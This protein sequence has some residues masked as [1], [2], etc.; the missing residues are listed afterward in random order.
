MPAACALTC[1]DTLF[2]TGQTIPEREGRGDFGVPAPFLMRVV[3]TFSASDGKNRLVLLSK[4]YHKNCRGSESGWEAP[5]RF[6]GCLGTGNG[7]IV[8]YRTSWAT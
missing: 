2:S 8:A 3:C 1:N 6:R 4:L 7:V 5:G